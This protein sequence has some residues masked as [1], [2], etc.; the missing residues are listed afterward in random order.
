M[1]IGEDSIGE[2]TIAAQSTPT[3]STKGPPPKRTVVATAD[4][5]TQPEP[6]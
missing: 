4:P 5:A 2:S 1:S 6:R 3:T